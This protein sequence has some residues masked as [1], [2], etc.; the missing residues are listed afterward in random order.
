[1]IIKNY[2]DFEFNLRE[3]TLDEF[4]LK[5]Q[6]GYFNK[7]TLTQE[8]VWLDAGANIGCFST[9][10]SNKVKS[11][12]SY[13]PEEENFNILNSQIERNRIKNIII[14]KKLIVGN[15]DFTRSF[16]IN[17]KKNKGTH[18]LL[19]K[20]GRTQI[21]CYCANINDILKT[22]KINKIKLD[23]EG[24]EWEILNKIT[25]KN[26]GNIKE[27]ILEFHFN[28]LKDHPNHEKYTHIVNLLKS[29]FSYVDY[30]EHIN[31]HW[32]TIVHARK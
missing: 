13:E 26:W 1:M 31:K 32:T 17:E 20:R 23:V 6:K 30:N 28:M 25:C 5:E 15:K 8:D 7:I 10:I 3:N 2:G 16:F 24:A 29:H 18:S 4:V 22:H 19:V 12:I 11:V 14:K 21:N 9:L 27:I